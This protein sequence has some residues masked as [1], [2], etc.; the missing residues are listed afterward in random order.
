MASRVLRCLCLALCA[1]LL[2]AT[3][4][5]TCSD[6]GLAVPSPPHPARLAWGA[7]P[8]RAAEA[9]LAAAYDR[10]REQYNMWVA[11]K[12]V[13]DAVEKQ[14]IATF[15]FDED[16]EPDYTKLVGSK[17]PKESPDGRKLTEEV[18]GAFEHLALKDAVDEQRESLEEAMTEYVDLKL[19][20]VA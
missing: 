4:P 17:L 5:P 13:L 3:S 19:K 9:R 1:I 11:A 15:R 16:E 8:S 6:T 10:V 14:G 12:S 2:Q 7:E 18:L 20:L